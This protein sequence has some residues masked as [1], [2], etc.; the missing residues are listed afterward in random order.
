MHIV[1][2][3]LNKCLYAKAAKIQ[4]K[5]G[6]GWMNLIVT[7]SQI[8]RQVTRS[9]SLEHCLKYLPEDVISSKNRVSSFV[10]FA[11]TKEPHG[12]KQS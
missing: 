10:F 11:N 12:G 9:E 5:N 6:K 3:L 2:I 8:I 4:P 1:K 7:F